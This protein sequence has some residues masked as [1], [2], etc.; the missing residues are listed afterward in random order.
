MQF[1]SCRI[2][3][4]QEQGLGNFK[5]QPVGRQAGG[6]K[7]GCD[8]GSQVFVTEL[9]R[10]HIDRH[11]QIVWP[12][13]G[14]GACRS[15]HPFADR[16]D[17]PGIF[18]QRDEFEGRYPATS[19]M[20]PP[21]Q[22]FEA[23]DPV[24]RQIDD[25][26]V[27][28]FEFSGDNCRA[29]CQ[30]KKASFL[31]FD[32]HLGFEEM[33]GAAAVRFC[34]VQRHVGILH[35][36]IRLRAVIRS[37]RNA[38]TRSDHDLMVAKIERRSHGRDNSLR[39]A[40]GVRHVSRRIG[41]HDGKLVAADSSDQI[42]VAYQGAQALRCRTEQ[43]VPIGVAERIVDILEL[44]QIQAK[45]RETSAACDLRQARLDEFAVRNAIGEASQRIVT[46]EEFD[47]LLDPAPLGHVRMDGNRAAG[48]QRLACHGYDSS[49]AKLVF[50]GARRWI[51]CRCQTLFQEC[52]EIGRTGI[53]LRLMRQD[54]SKRCA[55]FRMFT[56]E[57][58][59]LHI[60]RIADEQ[61]EVAVDHGQ[62]LGH[63]LQRRGE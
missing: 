17:E 3:V 50:S 8:A 7:C 26:L 58:I 1:V 16:D 36:L 60:F 63:A 10:R 23:A 30:F 24:L 2:V 31:G 53:G 40:G 44:V 22:C 46:G 43:G 47:F 9:Q 61:A 33:V 6:R 49:V 52:F 12:C 4:V 56:V 14:F 32:I 19:R 25:G 57:S 18:G 38:D 15:Q 39:K 55:E 11:A 35:D 41:L 37:N 29:Q 34:L 45:N 27:F 21:Q 20:V 48:R 51:G 59:H 42:R 28:E 62:A 5:L 13:R 54:G